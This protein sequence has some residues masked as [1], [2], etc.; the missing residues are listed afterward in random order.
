[1]EAARRHKGL[2]M[3]ALL[4]GTAA[5]ALLSLCVGSVSLS[6]GEVAAALLGR[7]QGVSGSI[8]LYARLPRMLAALVCGC[9]LAVG[10]RHHPGG[11]WAILWQ[12]PTSSGSTP[13]RGWEPFC[14]PPCCPPP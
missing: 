9:A 11:C 14:A 1:M 8:V 5:A 7:G 6:L 10:G 13:G 12:G 4:A 3:L 2:L